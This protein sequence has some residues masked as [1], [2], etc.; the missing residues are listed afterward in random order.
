MSGVEVEGNEF[1]SLPLFVHTH[2]S[3]DERGMGWVQYRVGGAL[4]EGEDTEWILLIDHQ[5]YLF[6]LARG[7]LLQGPRSGGVSEL[8]QGQVVLCVELM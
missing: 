5:M 2:A 4:S 6:V 1:S 7:V 8:Q 3:R